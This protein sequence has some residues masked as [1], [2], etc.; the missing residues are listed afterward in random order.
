[1]TE[2][3][4]I[5]VISALAV[6]EACLE[7]FPQ[8]EA[9]SGHPINVTWTGTGDIRKRM[10][11]GETCD[12]V[13][14]SSDGLAELLKAAVVMLGTVTPLV[15][16]GMGAAVRAGAPVPDIG[17][18]QGL[19]DALVAAESVGRSSGPSGLHLERVCE[20]LGIGEQVAAKTRNHSLGPDRRHAA[21]QRRGGPG[22]PA[23]AGAS[24]RRGDHLRRPAAARRAEHDD[25]FRRDSSRGAGAGSGQG[26]ARLPGIGRHRGHLP[27]SRA[28]AGA[29]RLTAAYPVRRAAERLVSGP[30]AAPGRR[31]G[32]G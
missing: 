7:L 15:T 18:V 24:A 2:S 8:F 28:G 25:I 5:N 10:A 26:A 22:L 13:I 19:R 31:A 32:S 14:T 6:R 20:D 23:G 21:C 16:C 11:S 27:P 1:M 30:P 12:L 4:P 17:T 3:A 29:R 9:A